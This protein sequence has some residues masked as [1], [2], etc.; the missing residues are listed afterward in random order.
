M[1]WLRVGRG[2]AGCGEEGEMLCI[3]GTREG[4]L[5]GAAK[6]VECCAVESREGARLGAAREMS[7][8]DHG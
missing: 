3:H 5:L 7:S 8:M 2:Y 4:A 6:S 1:L